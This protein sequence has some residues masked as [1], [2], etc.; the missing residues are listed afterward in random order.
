MILI[1]FGIFVVLLMIELLSNKLVTIWYVM[2]ALFAMIS[3]VY[4]NSLIY[5]LIIFGGVSFI[6]RIGTK[7]VV[8][9]LKVKTNKPKSTRKNN[10]T[11][12]KSSNKATNKTKSNTTKKKSSK[13]STKKKK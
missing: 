4:T 5:Q 3:A 2:G 10:T 1:W 6:A 7:Y 11:K 12:K 13:K 8:K 9:D